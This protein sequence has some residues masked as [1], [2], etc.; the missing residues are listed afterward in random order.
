MQVFVGTLGFSQ[1]I[2][3]EAT[4]DQKSRNFVESHCRMYKFFEGVPSVT[5]P[6]CLKQG[7]TRTH[8][9]DPNINISYQSMAKDFGT[10][11]VPA[12]PRK[13]KDKSLVELAVK[14][15]IRLY[16]W[17]FR[18]TTATSPAQVN[19]QLVEVVGIINNKPHTRFKISRQESWVNNEKSKL[20]PLPKGDFE[21]ATFKSVK[22]HDDCHVEI[23]D[24]F[25][26]CPK[27]FR[28]LKVQA[29]ITERRVEIFFD[30]ERIALHDRNKSK[31][32]DRITDQTHLPDNARAYLEAT[33]QNVLSQA[34]FLS[35]SLH[36][37]IDELFKENTMGQLRRS[38]GLVRKAR[39][40]IHK[41]GGDRARLH[42]SVSRL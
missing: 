9:Y 8:L 18:N 3:A 23:E 5:V 12:R 7:V 21:Y 10:A 19:L 6:D 1:I 20:K 36:N 27:E 34:K 38:L 2:Y 22:I 4:S 13:P 25:Y 31:H 41:I 33:P 35:E 16:R 40:E 24:N 39:E 28:G 15:I 14:L 37:L 32:G 42:I 17:R 29:K 11:I 26:S 30:L